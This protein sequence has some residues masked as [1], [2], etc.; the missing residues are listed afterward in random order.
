MTTRTKETLGGIL[1]VA[2][3]A[4]G[5]FAAQ[6]FQDEIARYLDFGA[7]GMLLYVLAGILATVVAPITTA[8]LIPIATSLWGPVITGILSVI[9]WSTGAVMSFYLAR[10][11]G[12]PLVARVV[13]LRKISKYERVLGET[14]LFWNLVFLRMAVPVDVLS[15]A[16]GLFTSIKPGI[17]IVATIIGIT[18]FAFLLPYA[19]QASVG[20]QLA[21]GGAIAV[22]LYVGYRRVQKKI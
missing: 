17:Y 22:M 13:D 3:F 7:A 5:V 1:L 19:S 21:V 15:Y 11:F 20:F 16:I 14:H 10:H 18:P 9:S 12:Q 4:A 2:L 8:P 6:E